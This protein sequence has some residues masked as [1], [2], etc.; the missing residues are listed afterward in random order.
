MGF[1]EELACLM[2]DEIS[3][4]T[5]AMMDEAVKNLKAGIVSDPVELTEE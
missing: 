5:L 2:D 4:K 1:V 3:E